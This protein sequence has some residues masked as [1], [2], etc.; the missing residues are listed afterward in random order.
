MTCISRDT[1]KAAA[2]AR[3]LSQLQN[4]RMEFRTH[5]VSDAMGKIEFLPRVKMAGT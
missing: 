4:A 2:G 1:E 3:N 5:P